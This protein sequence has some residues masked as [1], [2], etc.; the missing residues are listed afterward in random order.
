MG[1]LASHWVCGICFNGID[2][3]F[4]MTPKPS[5]MYIFLHHYIYCN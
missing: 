3:Q 1:K 4:G 2:K 5:G